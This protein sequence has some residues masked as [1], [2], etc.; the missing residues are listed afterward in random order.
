MTSLIILSVFLGVDVAASQSACPSLL[1]R[2]DPQT[3]LQRPDPETGIWEAEDLEGRPNGGLNDCLAQEFL[4]VMQER[5]LTTA[6][7]LGA[8]SGAYAMRLKD[9]GVETRCY[10]GNDAIL[11]TSEGLCGVLD[12]SIPQSGIEASDFTYSL[13]VGEHIPKDREAAFLE[14]LQKMSSKL[15]VLSWAL[16][17]QIGDGHVNCQTNEY[18]VEQMKDDFLFDELETRRLRS[19]LATQQCINAWNSRHFV[20][21]LMVFERK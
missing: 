2:P 20:D 21:T 4:R 16:P 1:Q 12:L 6:L 3:L 8:G 11:N 9:Q 7:D 14:N 10:D 19:A 5:N 18:I 13:E 17:G 15:L